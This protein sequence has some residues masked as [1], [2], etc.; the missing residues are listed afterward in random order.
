MGKINKQ[1]LLF[2][3]GV[4][5]KLGNLI[6]AS[7][8]GKPYVRSLPKKRT[9]PLTEKE[10]AQRAR[11]A[12]VNKCLQPAKQLIALGFKAPNLRMTE[13]NCAVSYALKNAVAGEYPDY[14]IDFGN[15]LLAKGILHEALNVCA[16]SLG[17]E[18]IRFAWTDNS[19]AQPGADRD[20]AI[21]IA[22]CENPAVCI[23]T[24]GDARRGSGYGL[25]AV[26]GL[27]GKKV[28]TYMSFIETDGRR[29]ADSIYTGEVLIRE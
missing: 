2:P 15:L 12:L 18:S 14:Y 5:G 27:A 9:T 19:Y 1:S 25:L 22:L 29:M 23:Y 6:F 8:K 17:N 20:M 3:T 21:L 26:K 16:N 11:F 24:V 10:L 28:H 13:H 7:W 4:S